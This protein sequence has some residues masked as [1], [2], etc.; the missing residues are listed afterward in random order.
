MS[1]LE[2]WMTIGLLMLAT[3]LTRTPL[4]L[5]GGSIK[6]PPKVQ[7]ALRYAPATALAGIVV[8]DLVTMDGALSL[9]WMN[10]KLMAGIGATIFFLLT[11]HLLGTIVV[12]MG[13]FTILRLSL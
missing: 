9:T 13:L 8:P 6:L 3:L 12:G 5:F 11:R 1:T 10:A 4:F 7:R 2:I